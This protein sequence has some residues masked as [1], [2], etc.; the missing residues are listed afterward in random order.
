MFSNPF[1]YGPTSNA[2]SVLKSLLK[3]IKDA[4]IIFAGSSLC[5]EIISD[6]PVKK[7]LLD[8]RNEDQI[9]N[10]LCSLDKPF[11]IGSQ[12]RFCIKVAKKLNIPCSFIDTLAWFW[13]K[14]PE[15]HLLADEIFWIRFSNT[16]DKIIKRQDNIH[17]VSSI[18]GTLPI[19]RLK[20]NYLTIHIGG[21]KYP[22][23]NEPP[24]AYLN[25]VAK[26]LNILRKSEKF[27]HIIF[28]GGSEAVNYLK[29][30]IVD[31]KIFLVSLVKE[32]FVQKLS[33]S[34]HMMTTA[35][36]SSSL[37]SFS[38]NVPTSFLLPLNLSQVALLDVLL[39]NNCAINYMQW[40]NYVEVNRNLKNMTE[41]DA[42]VEINKYA[43]IV[44][45]DEKLSKKF[46]NDFINM[47]ISIPN[48]SK[49]IKLMKYMGNSGADEIVNVLIKKWKL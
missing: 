30:K 7:V 18:I 28:A 46:V 11:V 22:L 37:E 10:Y 33:Q 21:A 44:D 49:Q 26:G 27:D 34:V 20:K 45:N 32:K 13:K 5:M 43:N 35:G 3:K 47:A 40:D 25:L 29:Q 14:I 31:K 2:A 39:K 4:D 12:N 38:L 36:V 41:K 17:I 15:D 1:G 42:I 23:S 24:Y 8:E 19:V 9:I 48:N 16:D 6:V